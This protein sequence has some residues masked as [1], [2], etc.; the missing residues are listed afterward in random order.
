MNY[1]KIDS[2]D[3]ANGVG[4]GAVLWV[5]GCTC[6]C[7]GC[8]NAQTWDF[9]VGQ[10]F[11]DEAMNHLIDV[12]SKPYITRLTLS[13]GHPLE[14]RNLSNINDVAR[15]FKEMYP[16][17]KLWLYTGYV[18]EDIIKNDEILQILKYV[19]IVVDGPFV[20]E[21]RNLKLRFRGSSNQRII[22]VKESLMHNKIVTME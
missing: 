21:L 11:D 16:E 4:V 8:H 15:T 18:W 7:K 12:C 10:T 2:C 20:S 22:D 3:I 1:I 13:G 5:S 9:N 6:N 14:E 17:K 19:D